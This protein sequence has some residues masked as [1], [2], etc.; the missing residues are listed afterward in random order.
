MADEKDEENDPLPAL[1]WAWTLARH[2]IR[3]LAKEYAES[4]EPDHSTERST[5][6]RHDPSGPLGPRPLPGP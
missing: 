3:R 1:D 5:D 4:V 6:A 2:R